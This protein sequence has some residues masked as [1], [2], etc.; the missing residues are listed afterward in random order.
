M[1]C[2]LKAV[3]QCIHKLLSPCRDLGGNL[4][5]SGQVSTVKCFE[6][7]PLVRKVRGSA[8]VGGTSAYPVSST[9]TVQEPALSLLHH[10]Q[11]QACSIGKK[12]DTYSSSRCRPFMPPQPHTLCLPQ[13][14]EQPGNGRVLVV[15]GGGSKRCALLGDNIAEM[16][17]KNGWS[18]SSRLQTDCSSPVH[19]TQQG[20]LQG[21]Q[22]SVWCSSCHPDTHCTW[23]HHAERSLPRGCVTPDQPS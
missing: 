8:A 17:Y 7:N 6:N 23:T 5:F 2:N 14:F 9:P 10:L 20:Q 13:A 22:H 19:V 21:Q 15:D 12:P 1:P 16:A 4:R 18:V 11:G 3:S